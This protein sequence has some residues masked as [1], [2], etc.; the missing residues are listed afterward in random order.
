MR[1]LLRGTAAIFLR[2]SIATNYSEL[3]AALLKQFKS[4][5]SVNDVYQQLHNRQRQRNENIM[6]YMLSMQEIAAQ[7]K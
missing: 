1:K 5:I 2:T 4:V 7:G 6:S 3:K